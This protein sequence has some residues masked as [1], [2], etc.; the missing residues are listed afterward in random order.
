MTDLDSIKQELKTKF[1]ITDAEIETVCTDIETT[2]KEMFNRRNVPVT[3]DTITLL[4]ERILE[5]TIITMKK[6]DFP[7]DTA[8][9]PEN[10]FRNIATEISENNQAGKMNIG[11]ALGALQSEVDNNHS[12]HKFVNKQ[13]AENTK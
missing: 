3:N 4:Q 6:G 5:D 13:I 10:F 12:I 2:T 8:N 11:F 7:I 9:T 1:S